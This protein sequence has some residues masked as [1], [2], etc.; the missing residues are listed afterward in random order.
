MV[1]SKELN[2]EWNEVEGE[3]KDDFNQEYLIRFCVLMINYLHEYWVLYDVLSYYL[4]DCINQTC[5][6]TLS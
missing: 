4:K 5:K 1:V 6:I 2:H 3:V